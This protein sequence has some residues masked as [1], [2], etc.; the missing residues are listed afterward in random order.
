MWFFVW[1]NEKRVYLL[2]IDSHVPTFRHNL[3]KW[4]VKPSNTN[5]PAKFNCLPK[6]NYTNIKYLTLH[7]TNPQNSIIIKQELQI[8]TSSQLQMIKDVCTQDSLLFNTF[9]STALSTY[10]QSKVKSPL[11]L[12]PPK[13][14]M[15]LLRN[16]VDL[17]NLCLILGIFHPWLCRKSFNSLMETGGK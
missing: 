11:L 13:H 15:G 16:L 17:T 14:N 5:V 1:I 10:I 2:Y 9:F 6:K 3:Y 4:L 7:W 12:L 8:F